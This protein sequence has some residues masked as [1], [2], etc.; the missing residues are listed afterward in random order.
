MIPKI[1]QNLNNFLVITSNVHWILSS[2]GVLWF[3]QPNHHLFIYAVGG[4][5]LNSFDP[6]HCQRGRGKC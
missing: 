2:S 5:L 4:A 3:L 6:K 1:I